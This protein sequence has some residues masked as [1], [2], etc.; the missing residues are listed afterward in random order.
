MTTF[1]DRMKEAFDEMAVPAGLNE[2]TLARIEEMRASVEAQAP[3][4]EAAQSARAS[5]AQGAV[6]RFEDVRPAAPRRK[7]APRWA[8][9]VAACMLV[10]CLGIGFTSWWNR[11]AA[12]IS[13]D[14]NPSIE[15]AVNARDVVVATNAINEDGE[16]LLASASLVGKKCDVALEELM[17]SE[18]FAEYAVEGSYLE[19]GV[20]CDNEQLGQRLMGLCEAACATAPC[21]TACATASEEERLAALDSGMGVCKYRSALELVESDPSM[22]LEECSH[23]SMREIR[24]HLGYDDYRGSGHGSGHHGQHS[25]RSA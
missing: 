1:D 21:E 22:T 2:R 24:E 7:A 4:E 6:V 14:M 3:A 9:A 15:L 13:M 20:V 25:G 10:V 17:Q 11:P 18:A 8:F 12:Y 19:L 23:M 5:E 16:T